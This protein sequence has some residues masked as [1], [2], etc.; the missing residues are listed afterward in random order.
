MIKKI[1]AIDLTPCEIVA[2]DQGHQYFPLE[3]MRTLIA[4]DDVDLIETVVTLV[5]RVADDNA[6]SIASNRVNFTRKQHALEDAG[7]RVIRAPAKRLPDGGFKQSDDQRLMIATLSLALRLRPDF[8]VLAAA[9]GDFAPMVWELR[10][11]GIRTEVMARPQMLA[12][13]LRR[14]AYSVIDLDEALNRVGG[15]R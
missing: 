8:L 4:G 7:A 1:F 12:S 6:E 14:A 5:E 9:D 13:D 2:R 11:V 3:A 15:A 10:D